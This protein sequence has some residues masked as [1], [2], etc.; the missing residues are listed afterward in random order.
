MLPL[1]LCGK[2]EA[3]LDVL[4]RQIRKVV[5][6]FGNGHPGRQ[7]GEDIVN[8]DAH[9]ADARAAATLAWFDGNQRSPWFVHENSPFTG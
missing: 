1:T 9:A 7:V 6:D 5:E 4:R 2:G 8:G 3:G